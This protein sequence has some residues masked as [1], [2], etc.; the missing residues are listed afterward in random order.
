MKKY[1]TWGSLWSFFGIAFQFVTNCITVLSQQ[2][3]DLHFLVSM[4]LLDVSWIQIASFSPDEMNQTKSRNAVWLRI[5][6]SASRECS[7]SSHL[8]TNLCG[9]NNGGCTHLCFA[10]TNSFVCACPDEPDGRP[11]STSEWPLWLCLVYLTVCV[12]VLYVLTFWCANVFA[13]FSPNPIYLAIKQ[14]T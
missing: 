6:H 7:L 5:H 8:G 9:V 11:C 10:K 1:F 3:W 12:S 2:V 13:C 14:F 4:L